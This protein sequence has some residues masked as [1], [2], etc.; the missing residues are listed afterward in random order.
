[1]SL[2]DLFLTPVNLCEFKNNKQPINVIK[3]DIIFLSMKYKLKT[4]FKNMSVLILTIN[5][6][7]KQ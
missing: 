7:E 5:Q 2:K 4:A 1:M 6:G 3:S